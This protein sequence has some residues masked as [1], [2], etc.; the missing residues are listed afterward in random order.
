MNHHLRNRNL[1]YGHW[2]G[3]GDE[4]GVA[5]T[6][7][8][9]TGLRSAPQ[10]LYCRAE[11]TVALVSVYVCKRPLC[12]GLNPGTASNCRPPSRRLC[13]RA[14]KLIQAS[15]PMYTCIHIYMCMRNEYCTLYMYTCIKCVDAHI[16]KCLHSYIHI[17][18]HI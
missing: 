1:E 5:D 9:T 12:G 13:K 3:H 10:H 14:A 16:Y 18:R 7:C 11:A 6:A 15:L 8:K 2:H 4:Q 17:C